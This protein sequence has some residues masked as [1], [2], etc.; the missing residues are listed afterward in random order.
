M[1]NGELVARYQSGEYVLLS[2]LTERNTGLIRHV[3]SWFRISSP[4]MDYDDLVQKGWTGFYRAIETYRADNCK[5]AKFSTWAVYW[6]SQAIRRY[7]RK[8]RKPAAS[9]QEPIDDDGHTLE[10]TLPDND[11]YEGMWHRLDIQELRKELDELMDKHLTMLEHEII[12]LL[13]DWDSIKAWKIDEIAA[14]YNI[15]ASRVV[16][17]HSSS[18]GKLRRTGWGAWMLLEFYHEKLDRCKDR[19]ERLLLLREHYRHM[20]DEACSTA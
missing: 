8:N 3:T 19:P 4:A 17:I 9:I 11:A 13:Y 5:A 16:Y 20:L 7:I 12:K 10:D 15:T 1:E 18:L 14:L 6:I 2:D